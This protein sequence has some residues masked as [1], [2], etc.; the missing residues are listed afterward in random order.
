MS[1]NR[2]ILAI[3]P[4]LFALV[5]IVSLGALLFSDLEF[6][7]TEQ[8]T[9][10]AIEIIEPPLSLTVI[11]PVDTVS[12]TQEIAKEAT[13]FIKALAAPQEESITIN[14]N[15]DTFV[16]HD[17]II[18][19]PQLENRITTIRGL[20]DDTTLSA[21]TELTLSYTVDTKQQTTLAEL[22]D[23]HDDQ[24]ILITILDQD[25]KPQ[26][27]P[28]FKFLNQDN[29]DLIAP[30]T[31]L[32]LQNNSLHVLANELNTIQEIEHSKIIK[33][34][35]GHGKKE[36]VINEV[37]DSKEITDDALFY[38]HR[39]TEQDQQGLWGIIQTGLI[40]KFREGVNIKGVAS[41]KDSIQAVI[42]AD[43]DEKLLSG[44]SSF[45]GQI[46]NNKVNSS[47]IYNFNT[48]TMSHNPDQIY[49]EQEL[50][51]IHFTAQELA[52]I[53]QFFSDKRN[54]G[55]ETFAISD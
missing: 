34:S 12:S 51:M 48:D 33:V 19:L 18:I 38:L 32:T 50:V 1:S 17:S 46:L 36:I 29:I 14:E 44:L 8:T 49:P 23:K 52:Q 39:V 28:L 25:G 53:Y 5:L 31:V 47:Y 3:I 37:I 21:N 9:P 15:H 16:R 43:A 20:L 26:T 2:S 22:S 54:Q 10:S 40:N 35:I 7:E 4:A 6:Y 27:K 41:N 55:I 11:K 45:L 13:I 24:M 30:I 42:P